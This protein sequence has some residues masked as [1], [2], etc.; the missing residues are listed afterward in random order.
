MILK[1]RSRD[2][3]RKKSSGHDEP[4]GT[5]TAKKRK[6]GKRKATRQGVPV[7]HKAALLDMNDAIQLLKTTRPTFYRWLRTGRIRGMKVGRQWRFERAEIERFLKGEEPR[8]ELRT[9]ISPLIQDLEKRVRESGAK[10]TSFPE[11][12]PVQ[13]AVNLMI[14]LAL[15]RR[16]SDIHISSTTITGGAAR[17]GTQF[18][19]ALRLRIDGALHPMVEFDA[20]LL[21]PLV[22]QWKTMAACNPQ[23]TSRPQDGR[24]RFE[25]GRE[26]VNMRLHFLP[27]LHGETLTARI[28]L[29]TKDVL[30]FDEIDFL[31]KDR[32][33]VLSAMKAPRGVIL[34]TGPAGCGKTTVVYSCLNHINSPHLK[35]MTVEEPVEYVFPWMVQVQVDRAAGITCP[36]VVRSMLRSDVDVMAIGELRETETLRLALAAALTGHLVFS[37]LHTNEAAHTLTRMVEMGGEPFLI[38]EATKTVIAQRLIRLL[39][40]RCSTEEEPSASLLAKAERLARSGGLDWERVPKGFRKPV[41]CAHCGQTGYRG[42]NIIAEV[43]EMSPMIGSALGRGACAED[44]RAIAAGEGMTTMAA[45]GIL[46]A[47]KGET[48]LQEVMW[49]LGIGER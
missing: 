3:A 18:R 8:I 14:R 5:R 31:P 27:A 46:R 19:G 43:L 17:S 24:I 49:V 21:V 7:N 41:G 9:D 32:E 44:I 38:G 30:P 28:L 34:V 23:E 45:H 11:E 37:T 47:A 26:P 20:R 42:R 2:M 4:K 48:T 33:K 25:Y 1:E 6:K 40:P 22:E 35:V 13:R 15:A 12:T 29:T 10:V 16:A 39:C 36:S